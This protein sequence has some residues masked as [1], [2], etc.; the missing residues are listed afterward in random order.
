MPKTDTKIKKGEK[1]DKEK[2]KDKEKKKE[3][4][5]IVPKKKTV[6]KEVKVK[7]RKKA[8]KEDVKT[9]KKES[10]EAKPSKEK[11]PV[12]RYLEAVGRRKT[13]VARVR[14]WAKGSKQFLVNDKPYQEYFLRKDLQ[15]IVLSP[16]E[17]MKIADRFRVSVKVKGGGLHGQSVAIRHGLSRVL[18][19]FNSNFQKR[20][21]KV[22][23]LTR[24]SRMRE[25]KKFGLKRARR[26]PQWR[27][28]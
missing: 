7:K 28:R 16:L 27:K 19:K 20:L 25:R 10:K 15:E 26:A 2:D 11:E 13:S 24:D 12:S 6:K 5:K 9:K 8:T 1:K 22:G 17:K 3:K 21:K 14:F 18:I 23:F 4:K